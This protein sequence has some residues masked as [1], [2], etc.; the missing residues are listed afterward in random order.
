M[1]KQVAIIRTGS[2]NLASVIAAFRRLNVVARVVA[3][4]SELQAHDAIVLPGVGSF[5]A[6][7]HQ[8]SQA[9]WDDVLVERFECDRPTLAICLGLQLLCDS[10]EESPGLSGLRILPG[11][12]CRFPETVVV[13][14]FGWNTIHNVAGAYFEEGYVY[15][16][17]SYRL[18]K[19]PLGW[20]VATTDYAGPF[21]A[22]VCRGT[23]M[24]C[25]FHPELS[26]VFGQRLLRRWLQSAGVLSPEEPSPC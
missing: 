18:I 20:D 9:G 5:A 19:P 8:L 7:R 13:P 6:A 23:T 26:G 4:P 10:S 17:N 1:S 11:A 24:A 25:Q 2:A 21:V 15:Y 22:A 12:V 14:H 3:V 16:A